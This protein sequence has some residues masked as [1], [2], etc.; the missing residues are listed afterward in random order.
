MPFNSLSNPQAF[1]SAPEVQIGVQLGVQKGRNRRLSEEIYLEILQSP[2]VLQHYYLVIGSRV[3]VSFDFRLSEQLRDLH[4]RRW[5]APEANAADRSDDFLAWYEQL[6]TTLNLEP[7]DIPDAAP[8]TESERRI[9]FEVAR[10][11]LGL[12]YHGPIGPLPPVPPRPAYVYGHMQFYGDTEPDDVFYRYEYF[13]TS[14]RIDQKTESITKGTYASPF[15][16]AQFVPTGFG[17]VARFALPTLMPARWRWELQPKPTTRIRMGASVPLYGQAGG[18]VEVMFEN[19]TKNRDFTKC[20]S[21]ADYKAGGLLLDGPR[22]RK[23]IS[24]KSRLP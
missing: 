3:A 16:E 4:E 17:A 1:A 14:L 13:P 9:A 18:G 23:G 10:S 8:E 12:I 7:P 20:N 11:I 2:E 5:M 22:R 15:V 6:E 21:V 24:I 19:D